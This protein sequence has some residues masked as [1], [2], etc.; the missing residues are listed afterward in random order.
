[1]KRILAGI[2]ILGFSLVTLRPGFAH[3]LEKSLSGS[4]WGTLSLSSGNWVVIMRFSQK[5]GHWEGKFLVPQ[6]GVETPLTEISF[7]GEHLTIEVALLK[8]RYEGRLQDSAFFEGKWIQLGREFRLAL[9]RGEPLV[10]SRPQEPKSPYPYREEE[11]T[12]WN[13]KAKIHL[14]GTLTLPLSGSPFPA[15]ILISGSGPQDRDETI[16]AHHPFLVWADYLTR[17]GFAVLRF[18]DR[19][20]GKS[21]GNFASATSLDFAEDVLTFFQY[22]C[23]KTEIDAES[24]GFLGHSEGGY[25]ATLLASRETNIAFLILLASPAIP[26]DELL[27]KQAELINRAEGVPETVISKNRLLQERLFA[28]VRSEENVTR[29]EEE[30]RQIFQEFISSLSNE[31]KQYLSVDSSFLD[32]QV[33]FLTS[34]WFRYILKHDPAT[35]LQEVSCPVLALYGGKDLQVPALENKS[36]CEKAFKEGGNTHFVVKEFPQLN[37]LFQ[38]AQTGSPIEYGMIEETISPQV[39]ETIGEWLK[40]VTKRGKME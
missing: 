24:I 8:G 25:V 23:S 6:Q 2:L 31:E 37:H 26:W 39:L 9:Q 14:S 32:S 4:W 28:A 16:A 10:V 30:I 12:V 38:T 29:L 13:P 21:E 17:Q 22:L 7:D 19:G 33:Q 40:S 3:D 35:F 18:D 34:L 1:M 11:V 5:D 27:K 15:V 36:A 20:V